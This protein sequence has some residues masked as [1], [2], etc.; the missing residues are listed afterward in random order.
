L[1]TL[2]VAP[3]RP[4]PRQVLVLVDHPEEQVEEQTAFGGLQPGKDLLL[5]GERP[6][7]QPR[8]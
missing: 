7:V 5:A 4:R 1:L 6:W 3:A 8:E 2:A